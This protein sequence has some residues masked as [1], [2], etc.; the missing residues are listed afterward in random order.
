M[1]DAVEKGFCSSERV[2]LIQN[3]APMRNIDSKILSSRFDCYAFPF[4]RVFVA[5]FSTVSTHLGHRMRFCC[6]RVGVAVNRIGA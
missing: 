3:Q 4:Y 6:P 2:R 5:T 1:T